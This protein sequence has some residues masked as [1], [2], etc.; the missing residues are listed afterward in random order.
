MKFK[1]TALF[2]STKRAIRI[3]NR[4]QHQASIKV[5]PHT[6]T[7]SKGTPSETILKGIAIKRK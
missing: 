2:K 7:K 6:F 4:T 3:P 1:C 5:V